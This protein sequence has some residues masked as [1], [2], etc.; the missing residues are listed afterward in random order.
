MVDSRQ[1]RFAFSAYWRAALPIAL[2]LGLGSY[3]SVGAAASTADAPAVA[4]A[5]TFVTARFNGE[6][7]SND[8]RETVNWVSASHDNRALPFIVIDKVNAKVFAFD[9]VGVLRGTAPAL[10]GMAHGDDSVSVSA[11]SRRSR[12]TNALRLQAGSKQRSA[13]I[14]T[15]IS[16]GSTMK[17]RYRCTAS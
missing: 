5:E 1:P 12:P 16:C 6:T 15:R 9:G 3:G 7:I 2:V 13:M 4:A 11:S 10:L 14:S 17:Q 8:A